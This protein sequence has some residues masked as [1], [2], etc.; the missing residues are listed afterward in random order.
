MTAKEKHQKTLSA[1]FGKNLSRVRK[2]HQLTQAELAKEVG[3]SRSSISYYE[4]WSLNPTLDI[5]QKFADFFGI[6]PEVLVRNQNDEGKKEKFT[7]LDRNIEQFKKLTP[8]KQ[9]NVL[10]LWEVALESQR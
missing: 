7:R 5:V 3:I 2:E 6:S 8:Y 10:K 9:R 1:V 4:S